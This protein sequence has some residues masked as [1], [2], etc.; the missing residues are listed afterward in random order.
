MNWAVTAP[1]IGVADGQSLFCA[2]A[3]HVPALHTLAV[4]DVAFG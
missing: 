3:V 2:H 4:A 1:Q